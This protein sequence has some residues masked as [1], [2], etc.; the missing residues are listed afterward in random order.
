[1]DHKLSLLWVTIGVCI[2]SG[3]VTY[4]KRNDSDLLEEDKTLNI[5]GYYSGWLER[6]NLGDD[7][8]FH[9]CE[10]MLEEYGG[11][12]GLK[13]E[14]VKKTKANMVFNHPV[15]FGILGGGSL[16][17]DYY[18]RE[19]APFIKNETV[20]VFGTGFDSRRFINDVNLEKLRKDE[21][22]KWNYKP[23]YNFSSLINFHGLGVRGILTS[24]VLKSLIDKDIPFVGDAGILAWKYLSDPSIQVSVQS[25]IKEG[26]KV[27]TINWSENS[28][29]VKKPP[30]YAIDTMVNTIFYLMKRGYI[31]ISVMMHDRDTKIS[32][33][34]TGELA[35]RIDP[36]TKREH[37]THFLIEYNPPFK[38][39]LINNRTHDYKAGTAALLNIYKLSAFSINYRL[40]ANV[41][42][43]A[44]GTPFIALAYRF[45]VY[46]FVDTAGLSEYCVLG[47][48]EKSFTFESMVEKIEKIEQNNESIRTQIQT[49][50]AD[51]QSRYDTAFPKFLQHLVQQIKKEE[52]AEKK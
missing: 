45:K 44:A 38:T 25:R 20:M 19:M 29:P 21:P 2:F 6:G 18:L 33:E 49:H 40:H 27:V 15:K 41:L 35:R 8:L 52:S 9:I 17:E 31:V 50:I 22:F 23:A 43:L 39:F 12:F 37:G 30:A 1:M 51:V 36:E 14:L 42:S 11:P 34:L 46:D 24:K 16:L 7:L 28:E 4:L 13:F 47:L 48:D 5:H 26:D 3:V 10:Q 32:T